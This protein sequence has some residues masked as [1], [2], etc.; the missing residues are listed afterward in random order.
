[1]TLK[2][3]AALG[4]ALGLSA[5][6]TIE[7]S[8]RNLPLELQGLEPGEVTLEMARS[9]RV[10][11]FQVTVPPSLSSSESN[12]YYPHADIVW[13]GD[14]PGDRHAQVAELF[15]TAGAEAARAIDGDRSVFVLIDVARFHGVTE[16]TRYSVGGVYNIVFDM[17]VVDS[18]GAVIEPS[19]RIVA[20]L[21]APGGQA[22]LDLEHAGQTEKVR[23]LTHLT[24]VLYRELTPVTLVAPGA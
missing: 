18:S 14:G 6:A 9:Y 12:A 24:G 10:S 20:N 15:E 16:R 4:L 13:R 7:T 21:P 17:Q 19:R 8:T 22:A 5:C 1:M 3:L 11:G 2:L 23:V